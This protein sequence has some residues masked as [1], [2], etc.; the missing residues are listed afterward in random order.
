M[1]S[2]VFCRGNTRF[3]ELG[4][5]LQGKSAMVEMQISEWMHWQMMECGQWWEGG[6]GQ[7][8]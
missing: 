7:L 2:K 6:S 5:E 1:S 4:R 8:R 3:H